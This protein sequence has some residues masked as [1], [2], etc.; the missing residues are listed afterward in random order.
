[1]VMIWLQDFNFPKCILSHINKINYDIWILIC[2]TIQFQVRTV[3][4]QLEWNNTIMNI[5]EMKLIY[6]KYHMQNMF[7]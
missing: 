7:E 5:L 3:W 6:F 4:D 1:M 2:S